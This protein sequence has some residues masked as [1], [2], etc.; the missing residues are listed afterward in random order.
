[1]GSV[2]CPKENATIPM[3]NCRTCTEHIKDGVSN[4]WCGY[5][6]GKERKKDK[7][8]KIHTLEVQIHSKEQQLNRLYKTGKTRAAWSVERELSNLKR[9]LET[10]KRGDDVSR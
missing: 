9:E 1:M 6:I 10:W 2:A 8:E 4:Q 5:L 3:I 7:A